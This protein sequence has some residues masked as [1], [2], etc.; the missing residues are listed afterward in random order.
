MPKL[1]I[2]I[3]S[4]QERLDRLQSLLKEITYNNPSNDQVEILWLGDNFTN[5]VGEKRNKLLKQ[6]QGEY[7]AFVDDDD[8]LSPD[9]LVKILEA[10]QN[11]PPV[12]TFLVQWYYSGKKDRMQVYSTAVKQRVLDPELRRVFN[13]SVIVTP[14]N[15]LCAWRRE[16]ALA[17]PYLNKN[18]GEDHAWSEQMAVKFPELNAYHIPEVLYHYYYDKAVTRTQKR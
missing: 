3:L 10:T 8:K 17:V 4:L 15:H 2:C 7:V 1:T 5:S 12:I 9:Y 14:P 6:A 16:L 11:N 18:K 13:Q